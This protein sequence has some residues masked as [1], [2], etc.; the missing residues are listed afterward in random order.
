LTNKKHYHFFILDQNISIHLKGVEI[1]EMIDRT[2]NACYGERYDNLFIN[3]F[4]VTEQAESLKY[5]FDQVGLLPSFEGNRKRLYKYDQVFGKREH[6]A[7]GNKILYLVK[8]E[9]C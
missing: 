3:F 1:A 8:N 7:I 6:E 4:F 5:Y 9:S 2:Y